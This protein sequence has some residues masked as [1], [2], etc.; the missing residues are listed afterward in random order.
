MAEY[1]KLKG[2]QVLSNGYNIIP[3][4]PGQKGASIK[5]WQ[6]IETTQADLDRW[7]SNGR[8]SHGLGITT[9]W[10]PFADFDIQDVDTADWIRIYAEFFLGYSPIRIG[11]APKFGMVYRT[12]KPFS[13][14]TSK[15]YIDPQGRKAQIEILGDGQQFVAFHTHPDTKQPYRWLDGETPESTPAADLPTVTRERFVE[16]VAAC[17]AELERRGYRLKKA[18]LP[19]T[20][21]GRPGFLDPDHIGPD[22]GESLGLDDEEIRRTLMSVP[23]DERFDARDD[24]VKIGFAVA[25]ETGKSEFGYELMLEWSEQHPSHDRELFDKWWNSTE[26]RSGEYPGITFKYVIKIAKEIRDANKKA[27]IDDLVGRMD[28]ASSVE[29]LKEIAT[30]CS[31]IETDMIDRARLAGAMQAHMKRVARVT[32]GIRDAREMVKYR[33]ETDDWLK[34]WVYLSEIDRYMNTTDKRMV[35]KIAFDSLFG[36]FLPPD[37]AF[38]PSFYALNKAKIPTFDRPIYFPTEPLTFTYNGREC[39]NLYSDLLIPPI[40]VTFTEADRRAIALVEAHIR[41]LCPTEREM[42]IVLSWLSYIS[43]HR[44]RP[45]WAV[46]IQGPG[47]DGK[48]MI[49]AMMAGV[50][51]SDNVYMLNSETLESSF[52]AWSHGHLLAI[53]EEILVTGHKWSI[54]NRIKPII[55]NPVN[56]LH[57]KGKD[58]YN[59]PNTQAYLAFTNHRDAL[60]VDDHDRR[61]FIVMSRWRD[62]K[63]LAAFLADKPTYFDDLVNAMNN[64]AGAIR[65]WLNSLTPHPEFNPKGRAPFSHGRQQMAALNRSDD[66]EIFEEILESRKHDAISP[67]IVLVSALVS[68]LY[69]EEIMTKGYGSSIRKLLSKNGF[70]YLGR[71]R[72]NG[73]RQSAWSKTPEKWPT[74]SVKLGRAIKRWLER[75]L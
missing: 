45:N 16:F 63:D 59:V 22:V 18:A 36:R 75:D 29:D 73:E 56:E 20:Q 62:A 11:N 65:G 27:S 60:P 70:D 30:D 74:N 49:G 50:L 34:D 10:T 4:Y 44:Q 3:I 58:P 69:G 23:N 2:R 31:R 72:V 61:Y 28:F 37:S 67:E 12:D 26:K 14:I 5:N 33:P 6:K 24:W 47:G 46:V 25:R 9:K 51:G 55:T 19:A 41:N 38:S 21:Q 57:S 8:A 68:E 48:T 15:E 71:I 7:V 66:A 52:N 64:H 13:K 40:P 35:T 43:A 54:M 17:E 39:V 42:Q 53:I 1:L 32:I